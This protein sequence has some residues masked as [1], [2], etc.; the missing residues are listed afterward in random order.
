MALKKL[1]TQAV[2]ETHSFSGYIDALQLFK[3]TNIHTDK[4]LEALEYLINEKEIHYVLRVLKDS[5]PIN[6]VKSQILL[7]V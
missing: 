4:R 2:V 5:L 1:N 3:D 7:S 6:D